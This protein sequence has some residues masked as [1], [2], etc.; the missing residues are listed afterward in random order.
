MVVNNQTLADEMNNN[1]ETIA[2]IS[3][4]YE[5]GTEQ[6]R[7]VSTAVRKFYLN[8]KPVD[9]TQLDNLAKVRLKSNYTIT[10][11]AFC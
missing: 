4:L 9:Q 3:F 8:D 10:C 11:F 2:P 6:S 7:K 1:F 5:R